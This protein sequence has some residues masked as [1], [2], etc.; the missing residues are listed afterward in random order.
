M[1]ATLTFNL[2]EEAEEHQVAIDGQKWKI[3]V[4]ELDQC[5]RDTLK[6]GHT[7]VDL[8]SKDNKGLEFARQAIF[9]LLSQ[10][11]LSLD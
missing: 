4:S 3:V 2:P 7:F 6:Y 10:N 5:L 11:N 8:D 9:D 1:I